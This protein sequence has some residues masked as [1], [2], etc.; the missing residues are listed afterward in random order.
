MTSP[1]PSSTPLV[2][3]A[4]GIPWEAR[5]GVVLVGLRVAIARGL[6]HEWAEIVGA[7]VSE[8]EEEGALLI[9]FDEADALA[10]PEIGGVAGFDADFAVFDDGLII[11][12][13]AAAV[14]FGDPEVE[15]FRGGEVCAEVPFAAEAASVALVFEN[16]AER[17]ELGEG[18]VG[19]WAHH[20]FGVEE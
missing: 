18:V 15:A 9:L 16:F 20:V 5:E 6:G 14:G 13:T 11:H 12:F 7:V 2:S 1:T 8:K 19:I 10:G 4:H 17:A 3:A